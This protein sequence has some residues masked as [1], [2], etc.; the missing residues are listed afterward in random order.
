MANKYTLSKKAD[1][2]IDGILEYTYRTHGEAQALKYMAT[3]SECIQS[4][5][6]MPSIGKN[7][8]KIRQDCQSFQHRKHVIFYKQRKNDI[9]VL[10]ILHINMLPTKHL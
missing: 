2:D 4:L 10:A 3:L 1:R 9:F 5:A 6:E 8:D 7:C